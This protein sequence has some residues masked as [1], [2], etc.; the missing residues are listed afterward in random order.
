[1][2][3]FSLRTHNTHTNTLF[4]GFRNKVRGSFLLLCGR[5]LLFRVYF[6][7]TCLFIVLRFF[8][9]F[10][11][12]FWFNGNEVNPRAARVWSR[13]KKRARRVSTGISRV[14]RPNMVWCAIEVRK[15]LGGVTKFGALYRL[16]VWWNVTEFIY[17][18]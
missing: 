7:F 14:L 6:L 11:L 1:M 9:V 10:F 15:T 18:P 17:L 5:L 12:H 4:Q 2:T 8:F 16:L 3:L 13:F